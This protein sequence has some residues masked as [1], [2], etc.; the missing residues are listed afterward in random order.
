M[1]FMNK[2]F[3]NRSGIHPVNRSCL[4]SIF[5]IALLTGAGSA[6]LSPGELHQ[7]H[8]QLEGLKNC[9]ECHGIGQKISSDNCLV[10]HKLL[11][12]RI[13]SQQG[14]HAQSGYS[15][16][17][18]CHVE[19]HGR[20]FDLIYWEHGQQ[21]FN[22][23]KTG[24]A[25]EGKHFSLACRDCH[26]GKFIPEKEKFLRQNKNLNKTFLGLKKNCLNCHHDEHR[27]QL[28]K[29][30]VNCHGLK[31]WKPADNFSH[32][33]SNFPL[34]GKHVSVSCEKCHIVLTGQRL[35][36]DTRYL[37]FHGI[38]HNN[39]ANCHTDIHKNKFGQNCQSCHNPSGWRNYNAVNF[40]HSKTTFP[41]I[42]KHR[43]I[44]CEKCH[45]P[46]Q[47]LKIYHFSQCR[48]C[49]QDYHQAQFSNRQ[50]QKDC[51]A[52]HSEKG[53]IPVEFSIAEHNQTQF[54]LEGAHLAIPCNVCHPKL[55]PD[56]RGETV[57]FRFVSTRCLDCHRNPHQITATQSGLVSKVECKGCHNI[58]S[59]RTIDF[60]HIQTQFPLQD[61]HS[62][63]ACVAC[64]TPDLNKQILFTGLNNSCSG[65]HKD[66]H[67]GQFA[68]SIKNEASI[69]T[70][71]N[72]HSPKNWKADKFDHNR[73]AT[74]RLE[75]AHAK[76]DCKK[77]HFTIEKNGVTF[78]KFKP[79]P[80]SCI[81]C[82]GESIKKEGFKNET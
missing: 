38:I 3:Q 62:G 37:K 10:C 1:D 2:N 22:H 5:I 50:A 20:E 36:D 56:T 61:R 59:W 74:F 55:N 28:S 79:I 34:K 33:R 81:D 68:T 57:K 78:T 11:K 15:E 43:V 44:A 8:A 53:F 54:P 47:P 66:P 25:L 49:H 9:S 82:H 32:D 29:D 42:G 18:K 45:L 41:L 21:N 13:D 67:M 65:C 19:H 12:E 6:Q 16:C 7:S 64:H 35:A 52:C 58:N 76:L 39:C 77:C 46:N 4:L 14:L 60:D 23:L 70:C 48:D 30:C 63:V 51:K 24:F 72:C 75:G 40:D 26:Q 27:G 17:K 69:T 31:T 73:Q 71:G 80:H